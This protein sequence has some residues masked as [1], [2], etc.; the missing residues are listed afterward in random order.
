[1]INNSITELLSSQIGPIIKLLLITALIVIYAL[2]IYLFYKF[3]AKKNL[4]ELNLSQYNKYSSGFLLKFFA[5]IFFII[6]YIIILPIVTFFWFTVL[7]LFLFL[8][9]ESLT[10]EVVILISA[11]LVASVRVT[12]YFSESLSQDLAKMLPLTLL[13]FALTKTEFF[14]IST[15]L[16]R[17]GEIP[18]L[19]T[20]ILYY[21][22]FIIIIEIIMRFFDIIRS[23]TEDKGALK[24][25]TEDNEI[26]VEKE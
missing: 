6:E 16:S 10:L 3:L 25:H 9:A 13:G 8:L 24:S 11:A 23:L 21:L 14:D 22:S 18:T 15:Q 20:T 19:F 17:I 26:D 7:S 5:L 2:F 1:M 12:P 4:I